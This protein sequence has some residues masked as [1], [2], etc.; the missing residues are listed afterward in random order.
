MKYLFPIILSFPLI[1]FG[2]NLDQIFQDIELNNEL[3]KSEKLTTELKKL[4]SE[5][6]ARH[7]LPRVMLGAQQFSTNDPGTIL[8]NNLGQGAVEQTDFIPDTLNEPDTETFTSTRL[9]LDMPLYQGGVK[10][11]Q[12]KM[13]KKLHEASTQETK[14]KKIQLEA[15]ALKSYALYSAYALNKSS[16]FQINNQVKNLIS[17]Y[18]LGSK[19]NPVGYSGLLGLKAV[20]QKA[21]AMKNG[22]DAQQD[23]TN[24]LLTLL[25]NQDKVV[26]EKEINLVSF[27]KKYTI[28]EKK[29]PT[30][31]KALSLQVESM[32]K[33]DQMERARFLPQVG[34]FGSLNNTTGDRDTNTTQ[35]IGLYVKWDLFNNDSYGRLTESKTKILAM[36]NKLKY[37]NSQTYKMRESLASSYSKVINNL[38][39][40][41]QTQSYLNEQINVSMKLF[42]RGKISAIEMAQVFNQKIELITQKTM[43][44]EKMIELASQLYQLNH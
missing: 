36:K 19:N 30:Q 11:H 23:Y 33:L 12:H 41:E 18:K 10:T 37:A 1:A 4:E 24:K 2:Q 20:S 5:R 26:L 25:T 28:T 38:A 27:L 13:R 16:L 3:L 21:R 32:N 31:L 22:L 35:T 44:Y 15:Q 8:F 42:K 43:T 9:M 29:I 7:W 14:A 17:T 40:I 34:I 6:A 39:L